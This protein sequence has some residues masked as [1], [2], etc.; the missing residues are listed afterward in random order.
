MM[1]SVEESWGGGCSI[2]FLER[3]PCCRFLLCLSFCIFPV[4]ARAQQQSFINVSGFVFSDRGNT[5]IQGATVQLCTADG[6]MIEERRTRSLGEFAFPGL[7]PGV[8]TLKVSAEGYEPTELKPDVRVTSDQTF[9]VYMKAEQ[10]SVVSSS[11]AHSVSAHVLSM[12][13]KARE[14]YQS[15]ME[16]LYGNKNAQGALADFEQALGRAP[17]FYEAELQTGMALLSLGKGEEAEARIRRSIEMSGDQFAEADM[18]LG[19]LLLDRGD[20]DGAELQF[21]HALKLNPSA[22]MACY[23]LG[24]IAYRRGDLTQAETWAKKAKQMQTDLPMMDQLLLQVHIK[25]KNYGAA[26]EDINAYLEL[27]SVSEN[28][29][30]LRELREKLKGT[31]K[32]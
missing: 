4:A 30:R 19:V 16:K 13:R 17:K 2:R 22:W 21:Q 28:A 11:S 8:Y 7:N 29:D 1:S 25:Q 31:P 23:K 12:P 6:R 32:E 9:T 3:H 5:R 20:L 27:D 26:I 10:V 24:E 18:A 14:R 15:G